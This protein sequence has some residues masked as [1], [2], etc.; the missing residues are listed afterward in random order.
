MRLEVNVPPGLQGKS[1]SAVADAA[2]RPQATTSATRRS[3]VWC[4]VAAPRHGA[5]RHLVPAFSQL[6]SFGSYFR[7]LLCR[8]SETDLVQI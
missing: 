3:S 7:R 8:S 6:D 1:N 2:C 4:T 5:C